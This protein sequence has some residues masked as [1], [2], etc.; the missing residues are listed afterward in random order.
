M[1]LVYYTT[2]GEIMLGLDKRDLLFKVMFA[3]EIAMLPMLIGFKLMFEDWMMM[4]AI[5]LLLAAKLVMIIIKNPADNMHIYLDAIGNSIVLC[6]CLISFCCFGY[7]NVAL[8]A[9][10]CSLFVVEEAIRVYFFF[11]PNNQMVEGLNFAIELFMFITLASLLLVTIN[12]LV[13]KVSV[14]A[15]IISCA[16]LIGIQGYKYIYYYVINNQNK[17]RY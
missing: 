7:L 8:T 16:I 6:F 9:V 4:F 10:V 15:L 12:T 3:I 11:K 14:V 17:K 1:G 2:K 13:L 5:I